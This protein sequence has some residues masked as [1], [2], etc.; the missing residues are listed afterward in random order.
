MLAAALPTRLHAAD[1]TL[2]AVYLIGITLFGLRFRGKE[3]GSRSLRNYFLA[4]QAIP[5]WAIM[6]SIVSAE[7]S[8][9]TIISIPG[10]AFM[11]DFGFLQLVIGYV[12]GRTIVAFLFLPKYFKGE[13]YT[14]Y[15]L[16][17]NRF[18]PALHKVTAGL[19][20]ATRAAAE[21][22]RVFAVSIVVAIAIGTGDVIS[23]V[24]ISA[25][26]LLYTFE[27]GMAA[28]IWTDVVQMMI[29]FGGTLVAISTLSSHVPGGWHAIHTIAGA[30]GRFHLFHFAMN[31]TETYT[32][33]AGILGGT[34]LTMASH[35]TDQLMVQ[36]M[37]AARNLRQS[38]LA[39]ISSGLV[40]FVQ[41]AIFLLIG[42]GLYVFYGLH[43]ATF[44]SADRIFPTFIVQEMPTGIAGLLIAAILAAAMSNLSAAY[45]SLS[46]TT[47]VDFYM[48]LRPNADDRERMLISRSSTV[49]WALVLCVI[50]V[51]CFYAGGKGHVVEIGLSIASVAYGAL[52]GVFLLG[53]LARWATQ[54]GA[55]IGMVVGFTLNVW[56][57]Q[58]T[59]PAHLGPITIPR[60][61]YTWY[62]LIGAIVTFAIGSLASLIFRSKRQT[63]AVSTAAIILACL[64][65]AAPATHA[66]TKN[67]VILTQ[68]NAKGKTPRILSAAAQ[69]QTE[70]KPDFSPITTL[71][72][73]AIAEHRLPGAVV[74]I[75]HDGHQVFEQAYGNRKVAGELSPNGSTAAEPMTEDTIFDMASLSKCLSTAV[76]VM[77]LYEEGKLQFDDP[78]AKYLPAFA[79]NGK[80]H[81]TIR[82][83]LTHYSGLPPDVSL[84][85]PW[86]LAKPDK[87]EG[88]RRALASPLKTTPGTHFEYSD[89]NFI[90]LGALVEKL[91]G[92][93]LDE[94]AEQHIFKP[95]GM[96]HTRYLPIA[97]ACGPY[98]IVGAAITLPTQIPSDEGG[99]CHGDQWNALDWVPNIAPTTHDDEG[100]AQTNPHFNMLTR[101][102]VHDPTTRR[103]GGVA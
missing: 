32:F 38:Q 77:Q 100:N 71:M 13:M 8:T 97:E 91:S 18:G 70:T 102:T 19:F 22:V 74:L 23:I 81:V 79:A 89:I 53:T 35:G 73:A 80:E 33:W 45:N 9:L 72:N 10:L 49:I 4:D 85:D 57:W 62:V 43:P 42:A 41:F 88:I 55:I 86:G 61:A 66:Q 34:F 44:T 5:W 103:M 28:V 11:S 95:L 1:L 7:T 75:D 52:L 58:G 14:A 90:T 78:V 16:I 27:G 36:R 17:D 29:Y 21:G 26:T 24:L 30:A 3:K 94:Y 12:I 93:T 37:L 63:K 47:V 92:E 6:L 65:F 40:I 69:T 76:A 20:L 25:L 54:T 64:L 51:Y 59:F 15:Q 98:T 60:I 56:L 67:A 82:E 39:L 99:P 46:S 68:S 2:I 87:A 83:L 50:A 96:T 101:G 48:H 31:L 84:K